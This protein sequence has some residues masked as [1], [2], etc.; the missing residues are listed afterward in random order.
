MDGDGDDDLLVPSAYWDEI[1]WQENIG[2]G[3]FGEIQLF[4]QLENPRNIAVGDVDD[5]GDQ[6]F[7]IA[8]NSDELFFYENIGGGNFAEPQFLDPQYGSQHKL[9]CA[10]LDNDGDDDFIVANG[11]GSGYGEMSWFES[12]G[13]GTF[14]SRQ[15]L[16]TNSGGGISQ[17]ITSD[18]DNDG[19]EEIISIN[20]NATSDVKWYENLGGGL[21]SE[22]NVLSENI[23]GAVA[24]CTGDLDNDNDKDIIVAGQNNNAIYLFENEGEGNF[25]TQY[26]IA[27]DFS[28]VQ[29]VSCI[30]IDT[31]GDLDVISSGVETDELFWL[32]NQGDAFQQST[33]TEVPGVPGNANYIEWRDLN[34]DGIEDLFWL[35]DNTNSY[36]WIQHAGDVTFPNHET[37]HRSVVSPSKIQAADLDNDGDLDVVV[38]GSDERITWYESY[39]NGQFSNEHIIA[40]NLNYQASSQILFCE[41]FDGDGDIDI[42]GRSTTSSLRLYQNQGDATFTTTSSLTNIY[43]SDKS[44]R[45]ADTDNDGDLDLYGI[46]ISGGSRI[47]FSHINDGAGNFNYTELFTSQSLSFDKVLIMDFDEDGENDIIIGGQNGNSVKWFQNLGG[48]T[49]S[50]EILL[51]EDIDTSAISKGD[52]DGDGL[53][54]LILP[55]IDGSVAYWIKNLSGP[56]FSPPTLIYDAQYSYGVNEFTAVDF[57]GDNDLDLIGNAGNPNYGGDNLWNIRWLENDGDGSFS[58]YT[59]I[60]HYIGPA[61]LDYGDFDNDGDPDVIT[62]FQRSDLILLHENMFGNGCTDPS[63]CNYSELALVE[64]GTCCYG[65]CGCDNPLAENYNP[66]VECPMETCT[67]SLQG[68]VF[69]DED[70]DGNWD[71]AEAGLP[72]QQVT[73]FPQEIIALTNDEGYFAVSGLQEGNY[74]IA[75][76]TTDVFPFSTTL[77]PTSVE[78]EANTESESILFGTSDEAAQSQIAVSLYDNTNGYPCDQYVI[79]DIAFLNE[80][81]IAVDGVIELE[82]DPL[83]QMYSEMTEIDSVSDNLIYFSFEDLLPGASLVYKVRLQTPTVAFIGE[84]LTSTVRIFGYDNEVQVAYEEALFSDVMLCAYDP[85]DKQVF[86]IGYTEEH[87]ILNETDLD[88]LVRFQNTGNAPATNV[89]ITD[90]IDEN[91]DLASFNLLANSHSVMVTIRPEERVVEFLFEN[92]MLPDSTNDEPNSHGLVLYN[93]L[94]VIDLA[95]GTVL[96]NTANIYFDN[97]PPIITNTTWNTIHECG[98][99]A[100]IL[101]ED[102]SFCSGVYVSL[103]AP[104]P[105]N[106]YL[107]WSLDDIPLS[108]EESESLV[109]TEL[110]MRTIELEAGN[111]LCAATSSIDYQVEDFSES[112]GCPGDYDCDGQRATSDLVL[113]LSEIGCLEECQFDLNND[114][115]IT[116]I[117]LI[118]FLSLFGKSCAD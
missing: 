106:E 84:Q 101:L 56:A 2:N 81:N 100:E 11:N 79:H 114:N 74:T 111:P 52:L 63:A 67:Y 32:E 72:F 75:H 107:L 33:I 10:D 25:L 98:G 113:L 89:L 76:N 41:D 8:Y 1:N 21:F 104:Y 31:D 59:S 92:I 82:Y 94:P 90:T 61:C 36:G 57:D 7:F 85:N 48:G 18:L 19:D 80:G 70:E 87:L 88:F 40:S 47:V 73:I 77:N 68:S 62:A 91:F 78:I 44:F 37:L 14:S 51:M 64:D 34:Q 23:P 15:V 46:K 13:N 12:Y 65:V 9:C 20:S 22:Q 39:S 38:S 30:D 5:D 50:D 69:F 60:A 49:Y 112:P 58:N 103:S 66:E 17:V 86:P 24:I 53:E 35:S 6:D 95:P 93:I 54:D 27:N 99:E 28:N 55:V 42:L 83:F 71:D 115:A 43:N 117:D 97:N 3:Q 4:A 105:L 96:N 110:E 108:L 102:V 118:E 29:T 16:N 116:I 45:V 26:A 109:F